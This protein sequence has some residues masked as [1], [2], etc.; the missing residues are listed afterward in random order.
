VSPSAVVF[1]AGHDYLHPTIGVA[2]RYLAAGVRADSLF[3]TDL[4]DDEEPE[5]PPSHPDANHWE[6]DGDTS[7]L[8]AMRRSRSESRRLEV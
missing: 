1:S 8:E 6:P 5:S 3:R 4:G 2:S 7:M